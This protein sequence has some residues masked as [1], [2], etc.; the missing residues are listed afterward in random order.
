MKA[1]A[2]QTLKPYPLRLPEG[3]NDDGYYGRVRGLVKI[4]LVVTY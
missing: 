2:K 1:K 3:R 4:R